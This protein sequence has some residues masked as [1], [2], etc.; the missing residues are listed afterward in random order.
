MDSRKP[1][2]AEL[3][4]TMEE[5]RGYI[6]P[7][8]RYIAERDPGF[9][10]TF[11]RLAGAALLHG[12][13]DDGT[14][15]LPAKYRELAVCCVLA[16]KGSVDGVTTHAR[17]AISLGATEQELFEA[18]EAIVIPGGAPAFLTGVRGLMQLS[19]RSE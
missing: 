18:F 5:D 19:D 16:F 11:N 1:S 15:A 6:Y 3:L 7:A 10:D 8:H 14:H 4:K 2:T 9:L 17:R 13:A 12:N